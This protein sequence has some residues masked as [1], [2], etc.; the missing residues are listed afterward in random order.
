MKLILRYLKPFIPLV[1][2]ALLLL[3]AQTILELYLPNYM[4]SIVNVGIVQSGISNAAPDVMDADMMDLTLRF[5]DGADEATVKNAYTWVEAGKADGKTLKAY[6]ALAGKGAY[7]RKTPDKAALAAVNAAVS[8]AY[9]ALNMSM[10]GADFSVL[11]PEGV[12]AQAATLSD[13]A[14]AAGKSMAGED[15]ASLMMS[16]VAVT[17]TKGI[18]ASLGGDVPKV[19]QGYILKIGGIMLLFSLMSGLCTVGNGFCGARVSAGIGKKLRHDIYTKVTSFSSEDVDAFSTATLITRST[20][21]VQQVQQVAMMGI[22]MVFMAP[23]YAVGGII[24]ALR[25]CANMSWIVAIAVVLLLA[26][27]VITFKLVV[28]KFKIMQKL[29]D[30]LNLVARESLT[31]MLVIRAFGNERLEEER[32]DVANKDITETGLFVQRTMATLNPIENFMLSA[33]T[34]LIIWVGGHLVARFY[35]PVGDMMAYMQYVMQIIMAFLMIAQMF[36][37][38]PR[39]LV[40]ASRVEEVLQREPTIRNRENLKT[41]GGRAKGHIEF[42]HVSFKYGD[43]ESNVLEDINLDILPGQTVAFIGSTG[44]GKSTLI[45]LVPRFYDVTAGSIRLDGV[46]VRDLDFHELRNN[47]G[48]VPQKGVLFSG[49]VATNMSLGKEDGTDEEMYRAIR[50]AQAGD[51]INEENNGLSIAIAQGGEN[52]SGGQKQR[53]SIARALIKNPPIFIFDDSFSALDFRTDAA[54]RKALYATTENATVLVVAQRV[55]TIMNAD[56][57]FVL[58]EGKIVGHGTHREL[59]ESCEAYREIAES[60]LSKEELA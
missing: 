54:L 55:S 43:A 56:Q 30:R 45:N 15:N 5:T 14:V 50:T 52:V 33:V 17:L 26:L 46:D 23:L 59:L 32:F 40:A 57:I 25:K 12:L 13:S 48:Y 24:M 9:Y 19:Q 3:F 49:D 44:S 41:L 8:K 58:E 31:G 28:P 36:I 47:I 27:Q 7:V 10:G 20:N 34:L 21:D 29:T 22:R 6:P 37:M 39:A 1:V 2:I 51:F 38:L 11:G 18:H 53:L 4:S 42:D 35:M 60:Q 16:S